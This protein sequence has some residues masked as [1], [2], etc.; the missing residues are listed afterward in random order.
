[1]AIGQT[2]HKIKGAFVS[3]MKPKVF[4]ALNIS[5]LTVS[6]KLDITNDTAGE[7]LQSRLLQAGHKLH[8]RT[9]LPAN[10]YSI[11]ALVANLIASDD[12]QVILISGGTGLTEDDITP[13]AIEIMFDKHVEGFGEL[14]RHCSLSQIGYATLQSRATAG[15][16]N[17]TLIVAMPSSPNAC[18][19]AWDTI[20]S[21]QLDAGQKPCNFVANLKSVPVVLCPSRE[22]NK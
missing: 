12:V 6:K 19:T 15:L 20:L 8:S 18:E 4:V 11:R 21:H 10:K 17:Q 14:F 13:E 1:M 16:A 9:V 7:L 5:I 3:R 22:T 2:I